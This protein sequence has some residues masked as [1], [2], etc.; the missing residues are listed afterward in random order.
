MQL[1]SASLPTVAY[2]RNYYE[3]P[4]EP[5]RKAFAGSLLSHGLVIA[6]LVT[7]GIWKLT[8]NWG[9]EHASSGSV[10]VGMV[11]TPSARPRPILWPTTPN[12]W[13]RKRPLP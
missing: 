5:V 4:R 13:F 2:P 10:G 12:Q 3:P 9:T 7:S 6:M 11:K 1:R 8:S